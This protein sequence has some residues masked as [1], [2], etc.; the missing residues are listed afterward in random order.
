MKKALVVGINDYSFAP[1]NGCVTDA[2]KMH[3][4]LERN[5]DGTKN[6]DCKLLTSPTEKITKAVLSEAIEDLFKDPVDLAVFYFSGH[7]AVTN[8][9]GFLVTQDA[10]KYSE[11]YSMRDLI[12]LANGSKVK[13]VVL[14]IDCCYAG[15]LGEIPSQ[16]DHV[17]LKEGVS[18][19]SAC[20]SNQ[21][22][23]EKN[24]EGVFTS[25]ITDALN[26][27][28]SDILGKITIASVYAYVDQAL[29]AWDQRP[30]FKSHVSRLFPV[31]QCKP[32]IDIDILRQL[33]IYFPDQDFEYPLDPSYEPDADPAC[34]EHENI[35][36]QLQKCRASRLVVPIGE[37]HMYYAA[38]NNKSCKLTALG[39]YYWKLA[40]DGRI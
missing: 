37:E 8:Y 18:I 28:G 19:L 36:S 40:K 34:P 22:S 38:M 12:E 11:G 1:L 4:L 32:E 5:E 27:G 14:I 7:G 2:K 3:K 26:G 13:E 9:G 24:G 35:F 29:G 17:V 16:K 10:K 15:M 6:I 23:M 21:T 30:L 33:P 39:K 31:R 25:L 20:S